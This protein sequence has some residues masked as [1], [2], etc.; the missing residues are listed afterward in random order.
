MPLQNRVDPYGRIIATEARGTMMGNRGLLH[1]GNRE[2]VRDHRGTRWICCV[3]QFKGRKD[4]VMAPGLYTRLFFLDEAAAL[5][6]GHRPCAE[7][8]RPAYKAFLAAWAHAH[9]GHWSA[10]AVDEVLHRERLAPR[11]KAALD[12]L[13]DG[14]MVEWCGHPHLVQGAFLLPWTPAAYASGIKRPDGELVTLLT[15]LSI[16]SSLRDGYAYS[17]A[18]TS[19]GGP[20][21]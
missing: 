21:A 9:P 1:N 10:T 8:R 2:I 3:L 6:A 13:P 5:A 19:R 7:C 20:A 11:P 17:R 12:G 14:C 18:L 16:V 15:P 4:P